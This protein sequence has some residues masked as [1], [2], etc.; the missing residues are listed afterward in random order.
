M[1][2][3]TRDCYFGTIKRER[4]DAP[5][6]SRYIYPFLRDNLELLARGYGL[7]SFM[8]QRFSTWAREGFSKGILQSKVLQ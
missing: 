3:L 1:E 6:V 8:C 5:L 2:N 7:V 4:L